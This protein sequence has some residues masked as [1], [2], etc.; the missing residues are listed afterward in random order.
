MQ[1]GR[2]VD[3]FRDFLIID[4]SMYQICLDRFGDSRDVVPG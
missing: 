1:G 3:L 2:R 4:I